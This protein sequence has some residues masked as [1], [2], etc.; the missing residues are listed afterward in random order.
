MIDSNLIKWLS[1]DEASTLKDLER[2]FISP[3]WR[4]ICEYLSGRVMGTQQVVL[5]ATSWEQNREATGRLRELME[6]LD[7][8][9]KLTNEF[10]T[11]A[12]AKQEQFHESQ[13]D[14]AMDFEY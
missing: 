6:L 8:E 1:D 12:V 14:E 11:M 13:E 4:H 7:I 10:T 9:N 2:L 3:G 5:N